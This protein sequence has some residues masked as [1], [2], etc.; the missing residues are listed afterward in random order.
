MAVDLGAYAP[1]DAGLGAANTESR[2]RDLFRYIRGVDAGR[3]GIIRGIANE[4]LVYADSTGLW[5]KVKTGEDWIEGH[6]GSSTSGDVIVPVTPN[7]TGATR[8]DRVVVRANYVANKLE[9][10][11]VAGASPTTPPARTGNANGFEIS[12]AA[13]A[14]P[15]GAATIAAGAVS[16]A[17]DYVDHP[18]MYARCTLD[19]TR[20][21]NT[22]LQDITGM[23]ITGASNATYRFEAYIDYIAASA[24]DLKLRIV[25]P[26]G[27]VGRISN[28]SL[29]FN[30]VSSGTFGVV[31]VASNATN[32]DFAA[33]GTG[34]RVTVRPSGWINLPD[35]CG[36]AAV[37][38]TIKIQMAQFAANVS[39][40][41]VFQNSWMYLSRIA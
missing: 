13:V 22:T 38:M 12:L 18:D 20:N 31:D 8:V 35:V 9:F 5:V 6:W 1:F 19:T 17:R 3:S 10:D 30:S 4:H 2:W 37:P 16:D 27:A 36:T 29:D 23:S 41:T 7:A 25:T 32:V 33:A 40:A 15:N 26:T 34:A 24:A 28:F 39:D 21:N 11:C 14:V